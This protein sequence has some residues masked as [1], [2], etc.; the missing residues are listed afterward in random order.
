MQWLVQGLAHNIYSKND[1]IHN[2]W[3]ERI[4]RQDEEEKEKCEEKGFSSNII[5]FFKEMA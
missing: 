3:E 5:F 4:E 1:N 2:P